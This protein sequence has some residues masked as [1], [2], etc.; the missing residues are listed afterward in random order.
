V[1]N[2]V[3]VPEHETVPATYEPPMVETVLT[4]EDLAREVQFAGVPS[5]TPGD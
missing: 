3:K 5:Q 1:D 4:A 2:N